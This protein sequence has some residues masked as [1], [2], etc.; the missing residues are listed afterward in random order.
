MQ[1]STDIATLSALRL[2]CR[3]YAYLP[4][5]NKILFQKLCLTASPESVRRAEAIDS[6][7]IRPFVEEII[8]RPTK[9]SWDMTRDIHREITLI[10]A[11]YSFCREKGDGYKVKPL[12]E[13]VNSTNYVKDPN[14]PFQDGHEIRKFGFADF[15][16]KYM[17]GKIPISESEI[18]AAFET[19]MEISHKLRGMFESGQVHRAWANVLL[20]LPNVHAFDIGKWKYEYDH[21][22]DWR[23]HK[24]MDCLQ[25]QEPVGE[26]VCGSALASMI[27]AASRIEVL[28]IKNAT[29]C[30]HVWADN[31]TLDAL[32][33][34]RLHTLKID[35]KC[36]HNLLHKQLLEGEVRV[37][38]NLAVTALL[39][40][41]QP[42]LRHLRVSSSH[43]RTLKWP[44]IDTGE[45][46]TVPALPAL[47]SFSTTLEVML[48]NF[49]NLL[50]QSPELKHLE[51]ESCDGTLSDWREFWDAIRNHPSR[52]LLHFECLPCDPEAEMQLNHHTGE[53]SRM[54][55][56]ADGNNIRYSLEN[57]LSGRRHW[58]SELK[59][60][61]GNRDGES[62]EDEDEED[63]EEDGYG[64][65]D[66][67]DSSSGSPDY[68]GDNN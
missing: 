12:R 35:I 17:D 42:N 19:Y 45:S 18:E 31:G 54:K 9:Y 43:W 1:C 52:M 15:A 59:T 14:I 28:R 46:H 10:D 50:L 47:E 63:D 56:D 7:G 60:W 27:S 8:F 61:F 25:V 5:L 13:L 29:N 48:P 64:P 36:S 33:L 34:S 30:H 49:T 65:E 41:C 6:S 53:A 24:E 22:H 21:E 68:W 23:N 11:L 39:R 3:Q 44:L 32:D 38:F 66:D 40:K 58:D 62:A 16:Q 51:L 4:T 20:Q 67:G 2:A 55:W 57:Y 26:A 37:R